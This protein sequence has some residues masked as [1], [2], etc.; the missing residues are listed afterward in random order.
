[1][2]IMFSLGAI[3]INIFSGKIYVMT[4]LSYYFKVY[5]YEREDKVDKSLHKV[6][7]HPSSANKS[8]EPIKLFQTKKS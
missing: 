3:F 6:N 8:I 4:L 2:G 1:M 7:P 5:K